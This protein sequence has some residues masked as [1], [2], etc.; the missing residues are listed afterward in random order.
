MAAA[1]AGAF[2]AA[3]A[4]GLNY[5][6]PST[7]SVAVG[8]LFLAGGG[9]RQ[10]PGTCGGQRGL[11][12]AAS[13]GEPSPPPPPP[14]S[15]RAAAAQPL[16]LPRGPPWPIRVVFLGPP[17]AGTGTYGTRV[18]EALGVP[19]IAVGAM[20]REE[21]ARRPAVGAALRAGGLLSDDVLLPLLFK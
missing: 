16:W 20:L 17:G 6:A 3:A 4:A 18:A 15:P 9:L 13:K 14:P 7:A 10:A 12:T 2:R 19:H 8:A 1:L 11:A 21:A 5:S